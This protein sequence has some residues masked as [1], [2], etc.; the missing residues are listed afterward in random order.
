MPYEVRGTCNLEDVAFAT[1]IVFREHV[2]PQ[3][4]QHRLST[5]IRC[6]QARSLLT[7][8]ED[9]TTL[10][11]C[12]GGMALDRPGFVFGFLRRRGLPDADVEEV[13]MARA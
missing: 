12:S 7:A 3:Q 13:R 9:F 5:G 10:Q 6:V 8:H 1:W 2:S 4:C 11:F